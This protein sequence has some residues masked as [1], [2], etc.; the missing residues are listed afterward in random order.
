MDIMVTVE[1]GDV[2]IDDSGVAHWN[3][4]DYECASISMNTDIESATDMAYEMILA[5]V[6]DKPKRPVLKL[7]TGCE[8]K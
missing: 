2:S 6:E 7:V 5:G 8:S 4:K 3:K 1:V